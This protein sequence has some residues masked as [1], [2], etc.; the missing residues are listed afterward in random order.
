MF[1]SGNVASDGH[2][3]IIVLL[4][5]GVP[6]TYVENNKWKAGE[7]GTSV[8]NAIKAAENRLALAKTAGNGAVAY[9]IK[10]AYNA[11]GDLASYSKWV[12]DADNFK[13]C[14]SPDDYTELVNALK[15]AVSTRKVDVHV[16]DPSV[17]D[18]LSDAV[19]MVLVEQTASTDSKKYSVPEFWVKDGIVSGTEKNNESKQSVSDSDKGT[20]CTLQSVETNA[21]GTLKK[22]T[23]SNGVEYDFAGKKI[24]WTVATR[25]FGSDSTK[26]LVYRVEAKEPSSMTKVDGDAGTGTHAGEQGYRSNEKATLTYDTDKTKD[27]DHP[28]VVP[29]IKK[30]G[31]VVVKKLLTG[32]AYSTKDSFTFKVTVDS[33][34]LTDVKTTAAA[35]IPNGNITYTDDAF[36]QTLTGTQ[37]DGST[38]YTIAMRGNQYVVVKLPKAEG[39]RSAYQR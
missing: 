15:E 36:T 13:K 32:D 35:A 9:A 11:G 27:F 29:Q 22:A 14:Y 10:Y 7:D 6:N 23:Y 39:A 19:D 17:T 5:D 8:D 3:K 38:S 28:V 30:D 33:T 25:D 1:N 21:D 24:T 2:Q 34:K 37:N 31:Y 26:T 16:K 20:K 4:T 12:E 18:T